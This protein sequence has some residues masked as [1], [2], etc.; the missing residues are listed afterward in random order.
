M[1]V[2]LNFLFFCLFAFK[3]NQWKYSRS[4]KLHITAQTINMSLTS[5]KK[6]LVFH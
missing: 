2:I 6:M 5:P 1:G 3:K 4:L